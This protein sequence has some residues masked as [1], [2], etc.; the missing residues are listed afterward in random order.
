MSIYS[1]YIPS[2][3]IEAKVLY[4]SP[5]DTFTTKVMVEVKQITTSIS[6]KAVPAAQVLA[7]TVTTSGLL[8]TQGDISIA[9]SSKQ[10]VK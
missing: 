1:I 10:L 9:K 4:T 3:I 7:V 2:P 6:L 8:N 5:H